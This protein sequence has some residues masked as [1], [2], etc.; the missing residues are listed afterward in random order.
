LILTLSNLRRKSSALIIRRALH[1][2]KLNVNTPQRHKI[3]AMPIFL[4]PLIFYGPKGY[5]FSSRN[6]KD[7][8]FN[9]LFTKN[10]HKMSSNWYQLSPSANGARI[11]C[12]IWS[13]IVLKLC[14]EWRKQRKPHISR[15]LVSK[16]IH[17]QSWGT[18]AG[19]AL[20]IR[21]RLL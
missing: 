15:S 14:A 2:I 18:F 12:N 13:S 5:L 3:I 8:K 6:L 19:S 16:Y 10:F 21:R 7:F 4:V 20:I 17:R 1:F 9:V 11:V